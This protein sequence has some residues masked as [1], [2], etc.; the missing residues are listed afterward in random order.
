MN[1]DECARARE[2]ER[3]GENEGVRYAY[4]NMFGYVYM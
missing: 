1:N 2:R 3:E 4:Q